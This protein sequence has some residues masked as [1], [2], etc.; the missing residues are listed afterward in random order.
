MASG[1][2]RLYSKAE[3]ERKS[4]AAERPAQWASRTAVCVSNLALTRH[5]L[6]RRIADITIR[7]KHS[8]S[9][10]SDL[11]RAEAARTKGKRRRY[12]QF[13]NYQQGGGEKA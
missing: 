4:D 8:T 5:T 9:V 2:G 10:D 12:E 3:R 1:R 11:G 7:N 13:R 6:R